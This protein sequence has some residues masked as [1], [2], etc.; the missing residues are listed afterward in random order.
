MRRKSE[1]KETQERVAAANDVAEAMDWAQHE[2]H[3]IG[4]PPPEKSPQRVAQLMRTLLAIVRENGQ[5]ATEI[6]T[7]RDH[8]DS[9]EKQLQS[10][11]RE[12]QRLREQI[13]ELVATPWED[14]K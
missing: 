1:R 6:I 12:V 4:E 14:R 3:L 13:N 11:S 7:M 2:G 8:V 5:L 9:L 10:Y